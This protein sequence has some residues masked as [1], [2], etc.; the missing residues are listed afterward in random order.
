MELM[1]SLWYSILLGGVS[2]VNSEVVSAMLK[3]GLSQ[4]LE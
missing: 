4:S 2:I 3:Y 1:K